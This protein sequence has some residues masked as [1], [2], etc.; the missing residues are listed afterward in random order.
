MIRTRFAW[1]PAALLCGALLA[2]CGGGG[3]TTTSA[4]SSTPAASTQPAPA[5]TTT[6]TTSSTT[7]PTPSAAG[8]TPSTAQLAAA[9]CK[10]TTAKA[11]LPASLKAKVEEICHDYETGDSAKALQKGREICAETIEAIPGDSAA[12]KK[13]LERCTAK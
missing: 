2:G 8:P 1:I 6:A 3:S 9:V 10:S 4:T 11:K 5:A 7:T 13:A 12:K